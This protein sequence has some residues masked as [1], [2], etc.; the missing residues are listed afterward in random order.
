VERLVPRIGELER[1]MRPV[2]FGVDGLDALQFGSPKPKRAPKLNEQVGPY[3]FLF[4]CQKKIF[5]FL[6]VNRHSS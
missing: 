1:R 6:K 2:L 4:L 5:I 3:I